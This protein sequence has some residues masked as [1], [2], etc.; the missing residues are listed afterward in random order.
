ME[1]SP[2]DRWLTL[3]TPNGYDVLFVATENRKAIS[4]EG[5]PVFIDTKGDSLVLEQQNGKVVFWRLDSQSMQKQKIEEITGE[6]DAETSKDGWLVVQSP[7][8]G[9]LGRVERDSLLVTQFDGRVLFAS[10]RNDVRVLEENK[11]QVILWKLDPALREKAQVNEFTGEALQY[12][13]GGRFAL[14][15]DAQKQLWLWNL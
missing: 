12:S 10:G 1:L 7:Q 13:P 5:Q 3:Y 4:F 9:W 15:K 8:G 14:L 11:G 6:Y 2:H